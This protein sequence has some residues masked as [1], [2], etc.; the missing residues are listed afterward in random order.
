M[1]EATQ[2]LG[3]DAPETRFALLGKDAGDLAMLNRL[4]TI[5]KVDERKSRDGR[6]LARDACLARA[7]EPNEEYVIVACFARHNAM[8]SR[9]ASRA[10][11]MSSITSAPN[12]SR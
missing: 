3:F 5:V 8:R 10:A 11:M 1:F 6:Q 9:Y 12:F 4:D 2:G 7:H